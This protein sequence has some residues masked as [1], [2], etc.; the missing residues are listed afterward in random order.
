[1]SI[2]RRAFGEKIGL[3]GL[4]VHGIQGSGELAALGGNFDVSGTGDSQRLGIGGA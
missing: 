2:L 3:N 1:M 4:F